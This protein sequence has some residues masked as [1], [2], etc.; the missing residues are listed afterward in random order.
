V[1]A[2]EYIANGEVVLFPPFLIAMQTPSKIPVI[3]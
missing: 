2:V 1:L 3:F